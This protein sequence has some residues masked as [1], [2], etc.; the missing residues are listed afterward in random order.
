VEI[1]AYRRLVGEILE[2]L[3]GHVMRAHAPIVVGPQGPC[4]GLRPRICSATRGV[5]HV[6]VRR[7]DPLSR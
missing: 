5:H 7:D 2:P 1:A 3:S 6:D 4:R